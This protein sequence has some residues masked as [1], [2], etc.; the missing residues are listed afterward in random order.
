MAAIFEEEVPFSGPLPD[1]LGYLQRET[2]LTR[3]TLVKILIESDRLED[4][5]INPSRFMELASSCIKNELHSLMVNG[6]RYEKIDGESWDMSLFEKDD[7]KEITRYLNNLLEVKNKEKTI[8]DFV[9]YDSDVEREFAKKLDERDDIKLF[10][11][12]PYWFLIETP[13]GDYRPDWAIVK[14]IEG[15]EDRLYFVRETKG[16]TD[17][18]KLRGTEAEKIHCG[19]AHFKEIKVDYQVVTSVEQI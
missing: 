12:L 10:L 18:K 9:E 13:I 7:E 2:E 19:K 4:F 17:A 1:I 14:K 6:I 16:T 15:K 11:K 8:H 3:S 5:K